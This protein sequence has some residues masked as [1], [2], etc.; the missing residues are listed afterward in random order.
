MCVPG[1][2]WA[3]QRLNKVFEASRAVWGQKAFRVK[4]NA[5][6]RQSLVG[7][8]HTFSPVIP[9][10]R[11]QFFGDRGRF[12]HERVVASGWKRSRNPTKKIVAKV[13]D[14]TGFTVNQFLGLN[15]S[16]AKGSGQALVTQAHSQQWNTCLGNASGQIEADSCFLWATRSRADDHPVWGHIDHSR[17]LDFIIAE[18]GD[19]RFQ[20]RESLS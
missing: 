17:Q 12:D 4:L 11:S 7:E 19:V 5:P 6:G 3:G 18:Y 14:R 15:N 13:V 16:G 10:D 1:S 2:G 20:Y 8:R 9:G